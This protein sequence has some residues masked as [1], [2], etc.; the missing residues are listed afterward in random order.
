VG[1][2]VASSSDRSLCEACALG[3]IG[4]DGVCTRC[5][6]GF[7]PDSAGGECTECGPGC[8]GLDGVCEECPEGSEPTHERSSCTLCSEGHYRETGMALCEQCRD[9]EEVVNN[10][11]GCASCLPSFA[12]VGGVCSQCLSGFQPVVANLSALCDH[13]ADNATNATN[14]TNDTNDTE[15]GSGSWAPT[16]QLNTSCGVCPPG[17]AGVDGQCH[18]CPPGSAPSPSRTSCELCTPGRVSPDGVHCTECPAIHRPVLASNRTECEL[19]PFGYIGTAGLC[20]KCIHGKQPDGGRRV[21]QSCPPGFAGLDGA[22]AECDIGYYPND[23]QS[24]CL[25]AK[26]TRREYLNRSTTT[27]HQ[28]MDGKQVSPDGYACKPCPTA[29]AG[30]GGTC[31]QCPSGMRPYPGNFTNVSTGAGWQFTVVSGPCELHS[32]RTCVGRPSGYSNFDA[33]TIEVDAAVV[34]SGCSIFSTEAE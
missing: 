20:Y 33:C 26:C 13:C 18:E 2:G 25:S 12:G 32:Q 7:E 3:Y 29:S 4:V 30:D 31:A 15:S 8:A 17:W 19:C 5:E 23:D 22:C 16:I 28:C 24:H 11:T 14:D 10:R 27:C 6:N 9:G 1:Q 34:V 21:C